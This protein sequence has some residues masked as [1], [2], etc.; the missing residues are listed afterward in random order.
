MGVGG[1]INAFPERFAAEITRERPLACMDQNVP[2]K[3][4]NLNK[5]DFRQK[6]ILKLCTLKTV[7]RPVYIL[8]FGVYN[9]KK[10]NVSSIQIFLAQFL[11]LHLRKLM[12]NA[13]NNYLFVIIHTKCK[14]I[15]RS[16]V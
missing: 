14:Y 12:L 8:V 3:L 13:A 15:Y 2:L 6:D 7:K 10:A 11:A 9:P 1:W 16:F 5:A 4:N